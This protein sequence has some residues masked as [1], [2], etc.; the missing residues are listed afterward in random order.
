LF[1]LINGIVKIISK[2]LTNR[3]KSKIGDLIDPSQSTFIHDRSILNNVA[4]AQE[5]I[6][7]CTKYK[8]HAFFLKLDFSKAFDSIAS[9]FLLQTLKARGFGVK[10]C[11]WILDLLSSGFS[12]VLVNGVPS[13]AFRCKR[14]LRE[15][16]P[17]FLYL[18]ILGVDV[19][20]HFLS[21]AYE[22]GFIQKVGPWNSLPTICG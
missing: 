17:I 8:W 5:I 6:S 20:S 18:F 9:S 2:V 14:E 16:V 21:L 13:T 10:W 3:L 11:G 22:R 4:S 7:A 12:S 1:R 15:G 19:L